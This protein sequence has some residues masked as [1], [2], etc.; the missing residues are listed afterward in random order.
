MTS[1]TGAGTDLAIS[2]VPVFVFL[3]LLVFLDSYKLIPMRQTLR[4]IAVG[5][6]VAVLCVGVHALGFRLSGGARR[7]YGG[8]GIP[9]IEESLKGAY[10]FWMTRTGRVGFM[11]DGAIAGFALGAGFSLI[12][13]IYYL[14]IIEGGTLLVW[15]LRGCGTAMMHGGTTAIVG[16]LA[17]H[18]ASRRGGAGAPALIPG[19][20]VAVVIHSVYN[21]SPLSPPYSAALILALLP[22]VMALVFR[23][24][25]RSLEEWLREGF[26]ADIEMLD[27][28]AKGGLAETHAGRYLESL[29]RSFTPEVVADMFCLIQLSLELAVRAKG[30]LLRREAGFES[31]PDPEVKRKIDEMEYLRRNIG[32]AG[33]LALEPLVA[34]SARDIWQLRLLGCQ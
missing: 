25:E 34:G 10:V 5:C 8:L 24:S 16:I 12:E 3:V 1:W 20:A 17:A 32:R 31:P 26:D 9:L 4:S 21:F 22:G 14:R 6:G 19:L 30:D 2:V 13:N 23:S 7:Y 18:F 33:L 29:R 28:I 15:L 27:T 11:V